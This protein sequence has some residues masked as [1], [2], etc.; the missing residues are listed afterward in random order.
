[1]QRRQQELNDK[2]NRRSELEKFTGGILGG[3]GAFG[4]GGFGLG[5]IIPGIGDVLNP[6]GVINELHGLIPGIHE[7]EN[8]MRLG[9]NRAT[10][11]RAAIINLTPQLE[12]MQT[13][14]Q[15]TGEINAFWSAFST[16][17]V[18]ADTLTIGFKSLQAQ[19]LE[20]C[21]ATWQLIETS[22]AATGWT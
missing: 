4:F 17:V 10:V 6:G 19:E 7:L 22:L 20:I 13:L 8:L 11:F 14:F 15:S 21:K 12:M 2:N 9:E 5:G 18:T 16:D 1:M 3:F